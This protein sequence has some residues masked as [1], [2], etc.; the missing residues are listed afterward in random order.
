MMSMR[1]AGGWQRG[2]GWQPGGP[3]VAPLLPVTDDA[4]QYTLNLA[5]P[6][7]GAHDR[8]HA[9]TCSA[10]G[11]VVICSA[12]AGFDGVPGLRRVDPLDAPGLRRMLG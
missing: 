8:L 4:F 9:G 6:G 3:P 7:V 2:R 5:A 12:D 1:A 11:I 10:H